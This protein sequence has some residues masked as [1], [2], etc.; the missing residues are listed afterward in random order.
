M[1]GLEIEVPPVGFKSRTPVEGLEME[2]PQWGLRAELYW[3]VW[4]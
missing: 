3:R 4:R 1:E 2:V